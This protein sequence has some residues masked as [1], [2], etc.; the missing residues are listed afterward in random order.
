MFPPRPTELLHL[1]LKSEIAAGDFAID[2]TAGNGHDTVFLAKAV[3]K[4]GKVLAIDVQAQAI[5]STEARLENEGLRDRVMLHLGCHSELAEITDGEKPKAVIFNLG[6]LPGGDHG[7]ITRTEKTLKAL[8]AAVEVLKPGG[9]LAVVCYPGHEGGDEE[10]AA[11]EH[12]I[13]SLPGHRTA[14]YAM[15]ATDK[16]APFLLLTR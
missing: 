3:G 4:N 10:A 16:P 7:V 15:L 5:E 2:A 1:L 9:V 14:R 13:A 8:A 11:V 12:F 6:Y